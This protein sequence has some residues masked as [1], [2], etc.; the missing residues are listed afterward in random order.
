MQGNIL[1]IEDEKELA[2]IVAL[3][4]GKEGFEVRAV[5][6]AENGFALMET[7][8]PE[9]VIRLPK[10]QSRESFSSGYG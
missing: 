6:S 2:D 10:L 1:I 8:K 5:E 4:L 7:W 9:L 3:Y